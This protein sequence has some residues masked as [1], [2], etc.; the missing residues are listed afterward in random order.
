MGHIL[1]KEEDP[2]YETRIPWAQLKYANGCSF[3]HFQVPPALR[4]PIQYFSAN[5]PRSTNV[6]AKHTHNN[7]MKPSLCKHKLISKLNMGWLNVRR[8][9]VQFCT[10]AT[11]KQLIL[12]IKQN[13][14]HTLLSIGWFQDCI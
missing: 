5:C 9:S 4:N 11:L 12:F 3:C 6:S 1:N 13:N 7:Y 14:S 10:S 2:Q 8:I